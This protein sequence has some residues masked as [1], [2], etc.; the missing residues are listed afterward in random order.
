MKKIIA[1][2]LILM[3]MTMQIACTS[4]PKAGVPESSVLYDIQG[5][6]VKGLAEQNRISVSLEEISPYFLQAIIAVE[7]KNFYRH[8]GLDMSGLVRA[9]LSNLKSRKIVAGG[10]TITQQTAKNL[11]LSNQR[12]LTRKIKEFYYAVLLEKKYSKDEILNMYCNTIYFGEGAYGIEVAARTYFACSAK[13]LSLAQAALLAGIPQWP[14]Q[15]DP[16]LH[17][18]AAKKR[19]E[20]VLQ[21]MFDEG[22][23]DTDI[24]QKAIGEPL[25]YRKAVSIDSVAPH[26]VAMVR[27]NLREKYGDSLVYQGGMKIYTSLDLDMQLAANK[28]VNEVMK[29]RD[30]ELEVALIALDARTGEIRAMV[31]G[32][33]YSKSKLNRVFSQRQ[34]GS[35][36]KPF[37]YSLALENGLTAASMYECEEIRYN[38]PNGDVYRPADYGDEPYHWRPFTIKEAIMISDNV[39][40]VRLL[41]DLGAEEAAAYVK[42]F[43]FSKIDPVLSLVLGSNEIR[44]YDLAAGYQ[45]FANQGKALEP[46]YLLS[47]ENR[48]GKKIERNIAPEARPVIDS[49]IAAIITDMLQGV[50]EP[51]GTASHLK[52]TIGRPAA[53]KTGTTDEYRDAWFAGYTPQLVCVVWVGYDRQRSVGA[54]G[55][56]IAG[57]ICAKFIQAASRKLPVRDFSIPAGIEKTSICLDSGMIASEACPRTIPMAFVEGTAP[58]D[59]C[60]EHSSAG[61]WRRW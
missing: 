48:Q 49:R 31:G 54:P 27:D 46:S 18:E 29:D 45:V 51:G 41:N 60:N 5:R 42:R 9:T 24:R 35:T 43:G 39:I 22:K 13:D 34:P 59:I 40:A 47:V 26:F 50:L 38:L 55:G 17:P 2:M 61:N 37:V 20:T 36:F 57:P 30:P 33:D 6:P 4:L 16:Y 15:Y 11:Y 56:S 8:H 53:A 7:D 14:S 52:E 21:R 19:Q 32:R 28:A 1:Y 58:T 10:S 44:P 12:T 25:D 23:I 3:M